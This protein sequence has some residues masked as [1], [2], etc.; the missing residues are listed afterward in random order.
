[1]I[2]HVFQT[3]NTRHRFVGVVPAFIFAKVLTEGAFI[4]TNWKD[5]KSAHISLPVYQTS[6]L[7][8]DIGTSATRCFVMLA[9]LMSLFNLLSG[10]FVS[11]LCSWIV[12]CFSLCFSLKIVF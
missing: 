11:H 2:V 4:F 8:P 1:M 3:I 9:Y 12:L 5:D 7:V 6:E 10:N